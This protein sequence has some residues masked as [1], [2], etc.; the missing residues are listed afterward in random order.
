T[1]P[2]AACTYSG[3]RYERWVLGGCPPGIDPAVSVPVA[4]GCRCGRCPMG[5]PTPAAALPSRTPR[6]RRLPHLPGPL[7]G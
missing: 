1:P 6:S 2:Q 4:L 7:P 5:L 3:V